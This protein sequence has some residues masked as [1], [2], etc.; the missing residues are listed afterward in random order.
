M[1]AFSS[2]R[3][4]HFSKYHWLCDTNLAEWIVEKLNAYGTSIIDVGCGNGFMLDYYKERF[5]KIAAIDPNERLITSIVQHNKEVNVEIKKA[6]AEN[7]PY[8]DNSFDIAFSKSSLHHFEDLRLG[9]LEMER[10]ARK[11]VAVMEVIAPSNECIPFL[12]ELLITKEKERSSN[13]IFTSE[14]LKDLLNTTLGTKRLFQILYDQY[15]DLETWIQY[16]DLNENEK[17]TLFNYV[18]SMDKN[19]SEKM[20]LHVRYGHYVMLRR[21][22]LCICFIE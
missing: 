13:S 2:Y 5:K 8:E 1:N 11:A 3:A 10:V 15:I 20:Q 7:I 14:K 12:R 9:L 6:A 19:I 21:M 16:S 18:V 4:V 22:C 17:K